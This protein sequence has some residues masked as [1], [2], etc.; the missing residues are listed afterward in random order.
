MTV[1]DID[2]SLGGGKRLLVTVEDGEWKVVREITDGDLTLGPDGY[3]ISETVTSTKKL[4]KMKEN[5]WQV[6]RYIFPTYSYLGK[7]ANRRLLGKYKLN[8]WDSERITYLSGLE[9]N[10]WVRRGKF[11]ENAF[12]VVV[13]EQTALMTFNYGKKSIERGELGNLTAWWNDYFSGEDSIGNF[14]V[15]YL[16]GI[17]TGMVWESMKDMRENALSVCRTNCDNEVIAHQLEVAAGIDAVIEEYGENS[18]EY[19]RYMADEDNLENPDLYDTCFEACETGVNDFFDDLDEFNKSMEDTR[20]LFKEYDLSNIKNW[21]E[22]QINA[23]CNNKDS[24]KTDIN[25]SVE[26]VKVRMGK[27]EDE[28]DERFN[29]S[30]WMSA[31]KSILAF[32]KV[33]V[34]GIE[35]LKKDLFNTDIDG[36]AQNSYGVGAIQKQLTDVCIKVAN[37]ENGR[38]FTPDDNEGEGTIMSDEEIKKL[39]GQITVEI[40]PIQLIA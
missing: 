19:N 15:S 25:A 9:D 31:V 6:A 20:K 11:V 23:Y 12:R 18:E 1:A 24:R 5:I 37:P 3:V 36:E 33:N 27:I 38:I 30:G 34:N 35:E 14:N 13:I 22:N 7:I 16:L 28:I 21:D 17:G 32:F 4:P 2:K 29:E 39:F 10:I 8:W 40:E 26:D